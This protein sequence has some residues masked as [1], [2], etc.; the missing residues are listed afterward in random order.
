MSAFRWKFQSVAKWKENA[1]KLDQKGYSGLNKNY[2]YTNVFL[3]LWFYLEA[4]TTNKMLL[5]GALPLYKE[6]AR[7]FP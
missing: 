6:V 4:I 1:G 5:K 7:G 2:K 3:C